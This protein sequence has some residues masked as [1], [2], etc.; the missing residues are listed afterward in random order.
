MKTLKPLLILPLAWCAGYAFAALIAR[1]VG[2]RVLRL[3]AA[4]AGQP[5]QL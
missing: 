3:A 2:E 1:A 5:V 4:L